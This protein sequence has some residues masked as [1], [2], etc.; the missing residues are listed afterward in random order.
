MEEFER[1]RELVKK[2]NKY[3]L[4]TELEDIKTL[5]KIIEVMNKKAKANEEYIKFLKNENREI[6]NLLYHYRQIH[7]SI[8]SLEDK[9]FCEKY[10]KQD[11]SSIQELIEAFEKH[12]PHID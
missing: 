9:K 8:I 11:F 10:M 2:S 3:C 4:Y 5:I 12:I 6:K 7:S 1:I